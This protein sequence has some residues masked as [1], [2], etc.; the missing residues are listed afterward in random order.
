MAATRLTTLDAS[1]LEVE[2]PSAHMHVGWAAT[3]A[4][5]EGRPRPRFEDFR[6]HVAGRMSR[7]PRYRQRLAPVP[8]GV[9]DP[10]WVDDEEFDVD[11]HVIPST[12]GDLARLTDRVLSRQLQRDRPLWELWIADELDD[13][14]IGVVGK[15]HHAMV[16]G[17]AAVELASLLLD[18]TPDPPSPEP[19]DW[20]PRPPPASA[21]LLV[22]GVLDRARDA[23]DLARMPL[24][25]AW[26]A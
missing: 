15:A 25:L 6:D 1:F 4:P 5:P 7:A 26:D 12:C 17:V 24:A 22:D 9:H 16:D 19:D 23:F 20:Q 14:R 3:F 8:L 2:S 10:V 18:P 21:A 11:R 13:G